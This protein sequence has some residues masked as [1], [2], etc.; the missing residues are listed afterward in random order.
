MHILHRISISVCLCVCLFVHSIHL[1]ACIISKCATSAK[2]G[3]GDILSGFLL[4]HLPVCRRL[5]TKSLNCDRGLRHHSFFGQWPFCSS[6]QNVTLHPGGVRLDLLHQ[7]VHATPTSSFVYLTA[8]WS[9]C[10]VMPIWLGPPP[11][12][13]VSDNLFA[14]VMLIACSHWTC[15]CTVHNAL[16]YSVLSCDVLVYNMLALAFLLV[17]IDR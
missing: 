10:E 3:Q 7:T 16:A 11:W 12:L 14:V 15:R 5:W 9:P 1:A 8:T 4:G 2:W 13:S 17:F 6:P